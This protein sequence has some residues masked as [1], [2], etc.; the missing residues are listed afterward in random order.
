MKR[1]LA[2]FVA[3]I[4]GFWAC[5]VCADVTPLDL[6]AAIR[7]GASNVLTL[8]GATLNLPSTF[9]FSSG[10]GLMNFKVN[11]NTLIALAAS[12]NSATFIGPLIDTRSSNVGWSIVTGAN[13]ACNTTCTNACVFG[14]DTDA[15]TK[16]IVDCADATADRCTCAGSS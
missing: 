5:L 16:P 12:D 2:Y 7:V 9:S 4:V 11:G 10:N 14:Q 6:G 1:L 8:T 15:A 3:S 13:T